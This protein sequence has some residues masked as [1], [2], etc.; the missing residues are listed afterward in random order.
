MR[1]SSTSAISLAAR[2]RALADDDLKQL[3]IAREV[4]DRRIGDFFDLA[5]AL[6]DGSS[7]QRA[8][9]RLDRYTLIALGAIA[10]LGAPTTAEVAGRIRDAVPAHDLSAGIAS[11]RELALLDSEAG[12]HA[13]YDAVV[14]QFAA[15]P[16]FG[17]PSLDELIDTPAPA[18]L[19]PVADPDAERLDRAAGE[20]A[21]ATTIAV[22]QLVSEIE[23]QPARE[24]AKGGIALPDAK[25]LSHAMASELS[26]VQTLLD[27]ATSSS[28]VRQDAGRWL[29]ADSAVDWQLQPVAARWGTLAAAW[30]GRLPRD[31]RDL[32][33]ARPRAIWG[34]GLAE[35]LDWLFPAG[36]E[37]M[38]ERVA[39]HIRDGEYLGVTSGGAASAPGAV[40]ISEGVPAATE[41]IATLFPAEVEKAYIQH[42]LSIVSPGP[43]AP[44]ADTRLRTIAEVES[45]E[46][47]T[48]YRITASSIS[49]GLAGGETAAS[50]R[51]FLEQLSLSGI[52]QPLDYLLEETAQRFGNLRVGR[53]DPDRAEP[54]DPEYGARTYVRSADEHLIGTIAVDQSLGVLAFVRVGAHRLVS[55]FD[56]D[57]VFWTLNEAR[58][59]VAAE[60]ADGEIVSVERKRSAVASP[61]PVDDTVP[62]LVHRLRESSLSSPDETGAAWIGRQLE[63]AV[64]ARSSVLVTV[65]MP[66]G[67]EVQYQLEPTSVAGGRLRARDRRADI[68]RTLP[69]SH[70]DSVEPLPTSP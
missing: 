45:R 56:L 36:G 38:R 61:P 43:L 57:T 27:I 48:S 5:E 2:L 69:L 63:L 25:R 50:I 54:G 29:P 49:R 17:L 14:D 35:Y 3:L 19:E 26:E 58:Y 62:I 66:D 70:I 34:E 67:S 10:E 11:A 59:P 9:S 39:G 28:L 21:Y 31:I 16:S 12:R 37:W 55:R 64:R 13:A 23:R 41:T 15:W 7:V 22:S 47:A 30:L 24:L 33:A 8:L 65:T 60:D 53:L 52:P 4:R 32:L 6:L 51:S 1:A 46:F 20:R 18:A 42:D 44:A 40:L 68:E